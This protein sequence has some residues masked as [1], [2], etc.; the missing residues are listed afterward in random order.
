MLFWRDEKEQ[1]QEWDLGIGWRI[2]VQKMRKRWLRQLCFLFCSHSEEAHRTTSQRLQRQCSCRQTD[3]APHYAALLS[4]LPLCPRESWPTFLR[5]RSA[6]EP[7]K[8]KRVERMHTHS[9]PLLPKWDC[10]CPIFVS[11]SAV[12]IERKSVQHPT[13]KRP[14]RPHPRMPSLL[15]LCVS[16]RLTSR[17]GSSSNAGQCCSFLL[18]SILRLFS[19]F[20]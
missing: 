18:L 19:F 15:L 20:F 7:R 17:V 13:I 9:L 8:E 1:I 2:R 16:R 14:T 4:K 11:R 10:L 3:W 12:E 6:R 5:A